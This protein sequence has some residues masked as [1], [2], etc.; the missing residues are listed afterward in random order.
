MGQPE[1][2]GGEEHEALWQAGVSGGAV[3]WLRAL[4]D[5]MVST[6]P[7]AIWTAST[8]D[9]RACWG[10]MGQASCR[11]A[12]VQ[13]SERPDRS[14]YGVSWREVTEAWQC[15][16]CSVDRARMSCVEQRVSAR[17]VRN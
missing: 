5:E 4:I 3:H 11:Y 1:G 16:M 2:G 9:G 14:P 6:R 10:N 7:I 13:A 12:R 15:H 8:S 17:T